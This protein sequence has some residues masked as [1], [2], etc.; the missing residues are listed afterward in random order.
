[1]AT[2]TAFL[3][4]TPEIQDLRGHLRHYYGRH[5]KKKSDLSQ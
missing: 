2:Q 1:M 4:V 3:E 5:L